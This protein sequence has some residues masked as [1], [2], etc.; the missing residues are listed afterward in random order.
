[1]GSSGFINTYEEGLLFTKDDKDEF[2]PQYLCN[3]VTGG[4][5]EPDCHLVP[6]GNY[7]CVCYT[8]ETI[9]QQQSKLSNYLQKHKMN[10]IDLIQVGLLTDLLAEETEL[11]E[12]QAR[13]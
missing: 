5:N 12:L 8:N 7:V 3:F 1:M 4:K 11:F 2:S 10:P 9:E 13:V 6:G